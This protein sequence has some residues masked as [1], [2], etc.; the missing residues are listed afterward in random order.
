MKTR[1]IVAAIALSLGSGSFGAAQA[2][3]EVVTSIRPV[4]SLVSA[5]MA[6]AGE[7]YLIVRG[8]GSP[9]AHSLRPSD[10]KALQKAKLVFWIGPDLEN[11][12]ETALR[13]LPRNAKIIALNKVPGLQKHRVRTHGHN[14]DHVVEDMH[15]WLSPANAKAMAGAIANALR[16]SDADNAALYTR[17]ARAFE[18]RIDA[19]VAEIQT[20]L[21]PVRHRPFVVFH[22]AFQY[23]EH[24]FGLQAA[25]AIAA[26]P[27]RPPGAKRVREIRAI[28][29]KHGRTCV[30]SEPQFDS[31]LVD[32][33]TKGG[34][35]ESAT[36]DPLGSQLADGPDHYIRIMKQLANTL[37]N[38]L[39]RAS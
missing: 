11:F 1:S 10:A 33:L 38:C 19:A 26:N 16:G 12:L 24:S 35:I 3:I 34:K 27:E 32:A 21:A 22:D 36:L 6:G 39:K 28:V 17:N 9:H 29:K 18:E 20:I 31:R 2:K 23:F 7:P 15:L 13:S 5:V 30:F 25:T 4:H 8:A 14:H 37:A